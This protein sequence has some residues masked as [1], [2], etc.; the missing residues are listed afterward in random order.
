MSTLAGRLP[1]SSG[2]GG[3][4]PGGFADWR[5]WLRMPLAAW[6]GARRLVAGAVVAAAVFGLGAYAWDA[7]DFGHT[8]ASRAALA[9]VEHR[10]SDARKAVASLSAL[11]AEVARVA[12]PSADDAGSSIGNWHEI[13]ALAEQTGLTLRTMEPAKVR[14]EGIE[15]ARPVRITARADFAGLLDFLRALQRLPVLAVPADLEVKRDVDDL[16]IGMALDVFDAL[17]APLAP[18]GAVAESPER[19]GDAWFFDPFAVAPAALAGTGPVLQ[20]VGL[21]CEGRRRLALLAGA[22]GATAVE[23]GQ[24]IGQERVTRIDDRGVTLSGGAGVRSL[25]LVEAAR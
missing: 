3:H 7:A 13:S 17:S 14:G 22:D 11:R 18:S 15:T 12:T 25:T 16:S 8:S 24:A 20:L 4:R 10:L 9:D 2:G 6:G 1:Q 19:D 23:A 21:L 5:E